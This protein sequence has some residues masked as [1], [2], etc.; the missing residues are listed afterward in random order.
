MR[1]M[2]VMAVAIF[3]ASPGLGRAQSTLVW[4]FKDGET[5]FVEKVE[6]IKQSAD[7]I[8]KQ[9][10]QESEITTVTQF[11]VTKV[12]AD[13]ATVEQKFVG[14]KLKGDLATNEALKKMMERLKG[15]TLTITLSKDGRLLKLEGYEEAIKKLSDGKA[16][17][18]ALVKSVLSEESIKTSL[19]ETFGFLPEKEV[20]KGD[21]WTR[22]IKTPLGPFGFLQGDYEYTFK[23]KPE[24]AGDKELAV[25]QIGVGAKLH[26]DFPKNAVV[27]GDL[28]V[29]RAEFKTESA[30]GT[31]DFDASAG[32]LVRSEVDMNVKGTLTLDNKGNG[33][34]VYLEYK[35]NAK[36]RLLDKN[37]LD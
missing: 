4:K 8:T 31:I 26:F 35:T 17:E 19:T 13:G 23:G 9:V 16:E 20:K 2:L 36:T 33:I 5:F 7:L 11:H 25:D 27:M 22:G 10:T 29:V 15:T 30:A 12:N 24:K 14:A 21:A 32:K 1:K 6:S 18:A 3:L 28:K 37:P 34:T